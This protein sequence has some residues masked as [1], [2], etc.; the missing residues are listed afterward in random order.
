M[1]S[2]LTIT[3]EAL[4]DY[5]VGIFKSINVSKEELF[6]EISIHSSKHGTQGVLYLRRNL[7]ENSAIRKG[8]LSRRV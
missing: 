2:A 5:I 6:L 1:T 4:E 3:I 8:L 7:V